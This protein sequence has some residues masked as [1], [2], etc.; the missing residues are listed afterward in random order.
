MSH[1]CSAKLWAGGDPTELAIEACRKPL[2]SQEQRFSVA[3]TIDVMTILR[4]E[5]RSAARLALLRL[6]TGDSLAEAL[7]WAHGRLALFRRRRTTELDMPSAREQCEAFRQRRTAR[8][9]DCDGRRT[10]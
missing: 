3:E 4:D 6:A 10:E 2:L 9:P 1:G 5:S 7:S 8:V